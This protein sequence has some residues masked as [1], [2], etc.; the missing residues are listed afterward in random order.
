[1]VHP[2]SWWTLA[3][4]LAFCSAVTQNLWWLGFILVFNTALI[5]IFRTSAP[6]SQSLSF[7]LIT[8]LAVVVIRVGFRIIFNFDSSESVALDLPQL[9]LDLGALGEVQLLGRVSQASLESGCRDGLRMAAIIMSI[10]MANSIANPRLLLKSTPSALYEVA[11]SIVIA[12]NMAPQIIASAKRV[13]KFSKLRGRSKASSFLTSIV[14]PTLEDCIEKSMALAA[15]MD[16]RGFGRRGSLTARQLA[17]ARLASLVTITAFGIAVFQVL[18]GVQIWAI[19]LWL[20]AGLVGL[21]VNLRF[22]KIGQI[23]TSYKRQQM[24]LADL[25]LLITAAA[26]VALTLGGFAP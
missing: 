11:A 12:I 9:H 25:L 22:A 26:P 14:I 6:W 8:A 5:A 7:Y 1:M 15:S 20:M 18:T 19:S 16:A 21:V 10:G 24:S 13:N 23:K 4:S 2:A 3:G 17:G